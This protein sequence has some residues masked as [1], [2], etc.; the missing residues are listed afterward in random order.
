MREGRDGE[1]RWLAG[2]SRRWARD[3]GV[4]GKAGEDDSD[5]G[6]D[7]DEGED[8]EVGDDRKRTK[9]RAG[10]SRGRVCFGERG[11]PWARELRINRTAFGGFPCY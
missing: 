8:G 7:G 5:E 4:N 9:R 11:N 6:N 2:A 1:R 10:G 3:D